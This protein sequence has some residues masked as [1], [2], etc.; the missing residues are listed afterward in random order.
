MNTPATAQTSEPT[1]FNASQ[2]CRSLLET[3]LRNGA[4][5]M[6]QQAIEAEVADYLHQHRDQLDEQGRRLVVGNGHLPARQIQTGLGSLEVRQPRVHDKRA[7]HQ[8]TSAILPPYL[9]RVA[10]LDNLIP[11][12][13]LKG[14][15]MAQMSHALKPILGE[16]ADGMS[17]TNIQRL[18]GQWQAD[19]RQWEQRDL[20]DRHYVYLWADGIYFNVRLNSERPCLLVIVGARADGVKELVAVIDGQRESKLSWQEL[21]RDLKRRGLTRPPKVAVGDGALGFWAALE[22]EYPDTRGQ[23]C[24]V[25]KTANVLDK[26]PKSVQISAKKGLHDIYLPPTRKAANQAWKD[27]LELYERKY[28]KACQCLAKDQEALFTFYDFP[29]EHWTHLRTTN[30][31]ESSF[32]TVRHRTRQTKGNGSRLATLAM[33]F[34]LLRQA[35]GKW[36]KLNGSRQLDKIIAGVL[37]IDGDEQKQQAA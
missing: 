16:K 1:D 6:L 3:T 18:L 29:A 37:F 12:L 34:Q 31:I 36:R 33:V 22:E 30:P 7:D 4:Q 9:R 28:P 13:Y 20:S 10:A 24:W 25:H 17:P 5:Q 2:V 32:A 11:A 23:R 8:F 14:V 21:L 15:S 27:F 35:E 26:L 19:H